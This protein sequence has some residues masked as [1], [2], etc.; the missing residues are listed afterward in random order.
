MNIHS[1]TGGLK[2]E[3]VVHLITVTVDMA[4]G[5]MHLTRFG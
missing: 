3:N 2:T 5:I 4:N 1:A